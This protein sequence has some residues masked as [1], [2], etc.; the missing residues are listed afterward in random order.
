VPRPTISPVLT[1]LGLGLAALTFGILLLISR[2]PRLSAEIQDASAKLSRA[3]MIEALPGSPTAW[4]AG[5]ICDNLAGARLDLYRGR[6]SQLANQAG[7]SL[8]EAM[9]SQGSRQ[10]RM[11]TS[12][13]VS[14]VGKATYDGFTQFSTALSHEKPVLFVNALDVQSRAQGVTFDLKGTIWCWATV[15]H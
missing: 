8:S 9:I 1:A 2:P 4:P 10:S 11:L 13:Q 3:Q 5:A 15:S 6:I 14:I 12:A 7:A